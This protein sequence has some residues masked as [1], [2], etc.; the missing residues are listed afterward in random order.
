MLLFSRV[1]DGDAIVE[2]DK[3]DGVL[4]QSRIVYR[5]G[6]AVDVVVL[7]EVSQ[8]RNVCAISLHFGDSVVQIAHVAR[9]RSERID[10]Q[11]PYGEVE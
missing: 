3:G 8:K 6:E 2:H 7:H 4:V 9:D 10:D 5:I 11:I 1:Y